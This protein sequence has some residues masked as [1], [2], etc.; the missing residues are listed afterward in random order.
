MH[1][2]DIEPGVRGVIRFNRRG[3]YRDYF[4]R[5]VTVVEVGRD[6]DGRV[7]RVLTRDED[8]DG[9]TR[10]F[11]RK[12]LGTVFRDKHHRYGPEARDAFRLDLGEH[13]VPRDNENDVPF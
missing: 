7:R 13:Y 2:D 10:E 3:R 1:D 6:S 11:T 9:A 8:G 12:Y 4:K 5:P